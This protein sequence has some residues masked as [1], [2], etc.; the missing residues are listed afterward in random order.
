[1]I[2][3]IVK[4]ISKKLHETFGSEYA[5]YKENIPQGFKE[6]CFFIQHVQTFSNRKLANRYFRENQFDV[7]FFPKDDNKKNFNTHEVSESLFLS[8]E[9]IFVL[10]NLVRGVKMSPEIVDG[11]LHFFVNYDMFVKRPDEENNH[12]ESL[13]SNQ[14]WRENNG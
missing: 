14:Q 10:D 2:N 11:V 8:L 1:M 4:G 7:M 9:Y 6:P 5:I 12:M 13:N 3:E